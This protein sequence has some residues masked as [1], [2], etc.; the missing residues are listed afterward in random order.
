MKALAT[1]Q[2]LTANKIDFFDNSQWPGSSPDLNAAENIG[3]ILKDRVDQELLKFSVDDRCKT[4]NLRRALKE[5][6]EEM[7][8]DTDLFER[9]LRSYPDRLAEVRKQCGRATKY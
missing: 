6:L 2:I 4:Q 8:N 9:L 7:K 1:Q 5:V 3:A